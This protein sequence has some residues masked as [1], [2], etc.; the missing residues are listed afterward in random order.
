[1]TG[2]T[3][4]AGAQIKIPPVDGV[5]Y[6]VKQG[7]TAKTIA[8]RYGADDE[9]LI[10]FNDAEI[11]GIVAGQEIF[12]PDGEV[13]APIVSQSPAAASGFRFGTSAQYGYNGYSFGYCTWHASNRRAAVGKPIPA[14]LGN[15][16]TWKARSQLAGIGVGNAPQKFAVLWHP[17]RDYYGHVGFVEEV[18]EDGSILVSDMNYPSWNGVSTR[19]LSPE[20]AA[21]YQYIY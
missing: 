9:E 10:A 14:N 1:L 18:Y 4:A 7:E 3:L 11:K 19:K 2:E 16:S 15:A 8:E 6:K 12:I 17:P 5:L 21:A 13:P 20:Q